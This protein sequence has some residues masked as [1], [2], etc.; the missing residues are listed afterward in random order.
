[1]PTCQDECTP[2]GTT[3]CDTTTSTKTCGNFDQDCCLDWSTPT[4]CQQAQICQSGQCIQDQQQESRCETPQNGFC[5]N[6]DAA[7]LNTNIWS[8]ASYNSNGYKPGQHLGLFRP[9]AVTVNSGFLVLKLTQEF[10]QVDS[11]PSG[12]IS[13]G[14]QVSTNQ[15]F[16]YGTYEYRLRMS[17]TS[18]T[19]AGPGEPKSGSVST[20]YT[21][22]GTSQ[23]ELDVEVEGQFPNQLELVT[24]N[25]PDPSRPTKNPEDREYT[26]V[27]VPNM[28]EGFK[29]YKVVWTPASTKYFVD[30]QLVATHTNYKPT[31]A[32][33]LFLSHWGTDST[34]FGGPATPNINRY[35][36]IDWVKFTPPVCGNAV[37]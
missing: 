1:M 32:A 17:S 14:G 5:E 24:W 30:N 34:A 11:N 33:H 3:A 15:K 36:Y 16:G 8:I 18:Q 9:S 31:Q 4:T 19:P 2:S 13:T 23:T 35:F 6:F 25:N 27:N 28:E 20:A 21:L 22:V 12:I 7:T 10:G 26:F 29:I 37:V